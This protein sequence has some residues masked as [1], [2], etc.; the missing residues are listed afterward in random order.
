MSGPA[1]PHRPSGRFK[2]NKSHPQ[3]RFAN[4]SN[5]EIV[6]S[7]LIF[8]LVI[9]LV[10]AVIG[11]AATLLATRRPE[12]WLLLLAPVIGAAV[13]M[14]P[15]ML[16]NYAGL[17]VRFAGPPIAAAALLASAA[18]VWRAPGRSF[19]RWFAIIGALL[20]VAMLLN[21]WP[22]LEFGRS[23]MSFMNTDMQVYVQT[24]TT[25]FE[26]GFLV[27]PDANAY[28]QQR[29]MNATSILRDVVLNRR[30]GAE[31]LLALWMSLS[32]RDAYQTYM[33]L[34]VACQLSLICT[35]CALAVSAREHSRAAIATGALLACSP[36]LTLGVGHQLYP[37]VIGIGLFA[38]SL[39]LACRPVAA[40]PFGAFAKMAVLCGIIL[41]AFAATYP[42]TIPIFC[43]AVVCYY[44][45]AMV[46]RVWAPPLIASWICASVTVAAVFLNVHITTMLQMVVLT[47]SFGNGPIGQWSEFSAYLVPS[48]LADLFG[49]SAVTWTGGWGLSP[50]ILTGAALLVFALIATI[51]LMWRVRVV[52]F[53][54][55]AMLLGVPLLFAHQNGF[56]LYKLAM[57]MQPFLIATLITWWD[58]VTAVGETKGAVV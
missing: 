14:L 53:G 39:L 23:W 9:F 20:L 19:P 45:F 15:T 13:L 55:F 43:V 3:G 28:I 35:G 26:K 57:Y 25:M 7:S 51:S 41:A 52:S 36:L 12:N 17:P 16:A 11:Y 27:Q 4:V 56:G 6:L 22:M 5:A 38:A 21:A 37:Q 54:L 31:N 48:G 32:G 10:F 34:I 46:R 8:T 49:L 2:P 24:A 40:Q 50:G 58:G 30:S 44:A 18:I 1:K 42:E 47:L 33:P 29:D